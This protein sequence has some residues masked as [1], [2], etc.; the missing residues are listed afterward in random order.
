MAS[1]LLIV[2]SGWNLDS[3]QLH[4]V[5]LFWT[6]KNT[7]NTEKKKKTKK[8]E[9]GTE[10]LSEAQHRPLPECQWVSLG[11][12]QVAVGETVIILHCACFDIFVIQLGW[13][14]VI[15]GSRV[16]AASS[17]YCTVERS[18]DHPRFAQSTGASPD[19]GCYSPGGSTSL[20]LPQQS[21]LHKTSASPPGLL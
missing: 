4:L 7:K 12:V 21:L 5:Q 15:C 3:Q 20:A 16:K 6:Q 13:Y 14:L 10:R 11:I 2:K 18:V 17:R 8:N 1:H 19:T 9:Q